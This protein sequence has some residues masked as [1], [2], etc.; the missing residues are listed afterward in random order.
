MT[1][2]WRKVDG[3]PYE[4]SDHGRVRNRNGRMLAQPLH[5]SGYRN[6]QLW[7]AGAF[8]TFMVHRLVAITFI[9]APPTDRHEVAHGNGDRT[10]NTAGNLRWVLHVENMRDRDAHGTTARGARNG[11]LKHDEA[12]VA[13]VR[14]LHASGLGYRRIAA[15]TGISRQTIQGFVTGGRR[16]SAETQ[17]GEA[18]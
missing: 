1:E 2:Q 16:K 6:V 5:K 4:V 3:W 11:K 9:G 8:K 10:N 12:T 13:N 14:A 17:Q 7:R 15:R 18:P